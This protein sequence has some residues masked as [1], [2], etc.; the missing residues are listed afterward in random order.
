MGPLLPR[1]V[2]PEHCA[3]IRGSLD[4]CPYRLGVSVPGGGGTLP[5]A[6]CLVDELL[7]I[8]HPLPRKS[9]RCQRI[10]GTDLGTI[11]SSWCGPAG[12]DDDHRGRT[13]S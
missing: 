12:D 4:A 10:L 5:G 2:L 8:V 13:R 6:R 7:P 3:T 9:K 11:R 1:T